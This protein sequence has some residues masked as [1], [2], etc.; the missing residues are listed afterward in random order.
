MDWM[1][2]EQERGITITSAATTCWW[3]DHQINIIDTPGHVDFTVEVERSCASSTVRSP[4]STVSPASSRSPRPS[5]A[6][7]TSTACRA[8]ASSTSSTAPVPS[9]DYCVKTI[10]RAPRRHGARPAGPDRRRG[11]LHRRRRPRS[12][13]APSTWRGETAIGEDYT[14]EEIP[15]DLADEGRRGPRGA[16]SRP[17]ADHDDEIAEA[18]PRGR[19]H[20][21]SS[22]S[23]P[24]SVARRW[25]PSS[26]RSCA[27]PRSRTRA[28]SPCSTRSS[29]S[30]PRRSTSAPSPASTRAT[31][32]KTDTRAPS[33][34]EPVRRPGV[35]DRLRPAPGQA[36]LPARLLRSP[37]GRHQVLNVTEGPQGADRQDLPDAR[38]QARRDRVGRRRPDRRRHGSQGHHDR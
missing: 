21:P 14:V 22:C 6:R 8:C 7:P 35:Q 11:R 37:R 5:G 33:E 10:R 20:R 3:K 26:T 27:A 28:S 18:V 15:A 1:E 25:P 29:T 9:F 30:C 4:C 36:D 23:R 19:R 24:P 38:Q 31:R 32:R 34:D 12:A 13:C 17:L 16:C 2:Q